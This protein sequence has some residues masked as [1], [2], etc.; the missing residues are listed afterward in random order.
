MRLLQIVGVVGDVRDAM[1]EREA[2]PTVYGFSLQRPQWW[3]VARLSVVVR[4]QSHPEA[5][6]PTLRSTVQGLR[7]DAPV[8]FATL[9]EVFSSAF[10][11]RRFTLVLFAV[12]GGIALLITSIGL[13]GM[14]ACSVADHTQEIGIRMALGAQPRD[15][16]RLVIGQGVRLALIGIGFGLAAAWA[17]TRLMGTLLFGVSPTDAETYVAIGLLFLLIAL[18][19]CFVPARRATRVDPLVALRYE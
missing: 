3:Q 1:L 15:V 19:A 13:Y 14:L 12:F 4:A 2:Q 17:L 5:L 16:L 10:D 18:V 6:I 11:A 7:L 9:E 8:S